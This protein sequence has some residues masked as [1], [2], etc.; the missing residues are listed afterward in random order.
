MSK[1]I[2][3]D[4]ILTSARTRVDGSLGLSFS[5]PELSAADKTAFFELLN[6]ELKVL[7]Q[8]KDE[9]PAGIHEV[10]TEFESKTPGQRLRG[11]LYVWWEHVQKPG[12]FQDWY[13]KKMEVLIQYVKD[14]LPE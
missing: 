4:V 5:T 11:V 10:K 12:E 7:L 13:R 9:E 6:R 3:T 8:P 1:A 2:A 14:Q